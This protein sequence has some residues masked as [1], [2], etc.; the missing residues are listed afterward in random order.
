MNKYEAK[1]LDFLFYLFLFSCVQAGHLFEEPLMR[2]HTDIR[3]HLEDLA[4]RHP[5]FADQLRYPAWSS[6][7]HSNTNTWGRKRQH[8]AGEVNKQQPQQKEANESTEETE[9]S[10][11]RAKENLRNT[12]PDMGQKQQ[13]E[14]EDKESRGQR[15]WSAPPD[16]RTQ[17][18][19]KPR[20]VSK[21]E[22]QPVN[23]DA[24]SHTQTGDATKPPMAPP[25]SQPQ[26]Q[27]QQTKHSNVRHIPIFVEG[28]DEPILPK[29]VEP[30]FTQSQAPPPQQFSRPQQQQPFTSTQHH[31]QPQPP[32]Q[33][34]YEPPHQPKPQPP[35]PQKPQHQ[36]EPAQV[37][38]RDPLYR[39]GLVQKEVDELKDKVE[40]FSGCSRSD[41]EYILL[42]E[43]LTRNL[44][45]LD[46]I[47]TEGKEE[48]RA[49]RKN[50]IRSIQRCISVLENK[51]PVPD[52][53]KKNEEVMEVEQGTSATDNLHNENLNPEQVVRNENE[54]ST[55]IVA[56]DQSSEDKPAEHHAG[57][58]SVQQTTE[59][60]T[61]NTETQAE[62][63]TQPHSE[64]AAEGDKTKESTL[65][66][67]PD[68]K[69]A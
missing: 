59:E 44:I 63:S 37:N 27:Q 40:K 11:G 9:P 67:T 4:H 68:N 14:A 24:S 18:V 55:D 20:F 66:E 23:P 30:E 65:N 1:L 47:E 8:D 52:G 6:D 50:T 26:Q 49:A 56:M 38:P 39:V 33:Q 19:D 32:P 28:R 12:V 17:G 15:S 35:H 42:D 54:V 64:L 22:I 2:G 62:E 45:K 61:M 3:T 25:K 69:S 21:I 29:N 13:H 58:K 60:N 10:R 41:K 36:H 7:N 46:D 43:L 31:F 34:H 16:N 51:V 5:E 57:E 48:V 53:E